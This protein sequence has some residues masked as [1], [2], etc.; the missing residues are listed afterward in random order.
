MKAARAAATG[1]SET[2]QRSKRADW[3]EAR[4]PWLKNEQIVD[5][6]RQLTATPERS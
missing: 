5:A 4:L 1:T 6:E 2:G 3:K